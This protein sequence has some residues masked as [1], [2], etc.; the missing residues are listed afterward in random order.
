MQTRKCLFI[1]CLSV[2]LA[3]CEK[4]IDIDYHTADPLYVVE[5]HLSQST[6]SV[7]VSTTQDM[8]DNDNDKGLTTATVYISSGDSLRYKLIHRGKGIYYTSFGGKAGTTYDL[9]VEVDGHHF[10]ASSTMQD[11]PQMNSFRFVWQKFMSERILFGDLKL[12][13][14]PGKTN[15]YFMHLYRNGIGYRWAVMTDKANPGAELQQLFSCMR[16]GTSDSDALQDGDRIHL[17]VRAID[18]AA[19]DYLYSMQVMDGNGT[20]P[21]TNFSGGCL[22]YFSAYHEITHD[23]IFHF[24]DVEEEE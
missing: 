17:V 21:L 20:N 3:G 5:A 22:G 18:R 7:K 2:L 24:S 4:D 8:T 6:T 1:A 12:Q 19:Y 15:Y 14:I 10:T 13:D 11:R 9:S 23:V 16:E